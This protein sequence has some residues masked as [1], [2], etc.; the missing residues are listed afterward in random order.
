VEVFELSP[1]SQR[2]HHTHADAA[3]EVK[4]T[5]RRLRIKV[6]YG[7]R[8]AMIDDDSIVRLRYEDGGT[9]EVRLADTV[10]VTTIAA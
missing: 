2:T 3:A 8:S 4:P 10:V 6:N 7:G 9:A 5:I 1:S